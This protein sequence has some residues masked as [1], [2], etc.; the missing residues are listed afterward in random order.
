[1][2]SSYE[3]SSKVEQ[4]KPEFAVCISSEQK[5]QKLYEGGFEGKCSRKVSHIFT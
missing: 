4:Q 2:E 5:K 3:S 1:M